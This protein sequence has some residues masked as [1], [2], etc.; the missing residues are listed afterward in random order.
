MAQ[1]ILSARTRAKFYG[2]RVITY[3]PFVQ[4][5]LEYSWGL[6]NAAGGENPPVA[7][8]DLK[9]SLPGVTAL[10]IV[11]PSKTLDCPQ[12]APIEDKIIAAYGEAH[13]GYFH[14]GLAAL[15]HSTTAFHGMDS[16]RLIVTNVFGT[17]HA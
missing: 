7:N 15:I 3:R 9:S 10:E 8:V 16:S 12:N 13:W 6:Q 11:D 2:A 17:V 1:D 14:R 4:Q 5:I